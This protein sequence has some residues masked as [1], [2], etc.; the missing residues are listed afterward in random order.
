MGP[1]G[2][3]SPFISD[4]AGPV[5][6]YVAG[7]PVVRLGRIP[8]LTLTLLALLPRRRQ[9]YVAGGPVGPHGTLSPFFPDP[10]G[11]VG[12]HGTGGPVGLLGTLSLFI[13]DPAGP[14]GPAG[15]YVAG[16]PVVRLGRIPHLT[17]TLM[18]RMLQVAMLAHVTLILLAL[19]TCV[20]LCDPSASEL[21]I[22][23]VPG[24][25]FPSSDDDP[26][27]CPLGLTGGLSP[28]AVA[29]LPAKGD[30]TV[31]LL[32]VEGMETNYS[33]I[34]EE[35]IA[36]QGVWS[37]PDDNRTPAIITTVSLF[38]GPTADDDTVDCAD[39]CAAWDSGF[40]REIIDG[41][42]VY[43]GGD[44]CDS[45]ESDW[46]DPFDI[47]G[48]EYVDQYNFDLLEGMG[49]GGGVLWYLGFGI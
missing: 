48:R 8:R 39:E 24:G 21:A 47:A 38:D 35:H 10:I 23:V 32:P 18:A 43:Y 44:L 40:Q 34:S 25:M 16:G 45:E 12:P 9:V 49:G 22:L 30:P 15:P 20:D 27:L 2:T 6:P 3:L 46:E 29:P 17:L 31:A 37:E 28:V 42:T 33:M 1:L 26:G 5:G 7:G 4:P 19:L 36:G 11:P 13:S 14:A 41:V